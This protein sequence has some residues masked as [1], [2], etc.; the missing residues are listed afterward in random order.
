MAEKDDIASN[1]FAALFPSLDQ[2]QLFVANK[3]LVQQENGKF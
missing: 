3:Q 1:P 2:A